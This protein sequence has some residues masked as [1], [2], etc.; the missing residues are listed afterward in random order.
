MEEKKCRHKVEQEKQKVG[1]NKNKYNNTS[2]KNVLN[3]PIR[4]QRFS[5][6][7]KIYT[8]KFELYVI[9]KS[10]TTHKEFDNQDMDK[11]I[12]AI[13]KKINLQWP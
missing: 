12:L 7:I 3:S 4:I 9:C 8:Y 1:S 11:N 10:Y 6:Q 2:N 5:S 13:I